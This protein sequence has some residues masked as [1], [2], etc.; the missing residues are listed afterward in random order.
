MDNSHKTS[1][2]KEQKRVIASTATGFS[3]ENMDFNFMSFAL[4]SIIASLGISTTEAGWINT[5]TNLGMLVGG[6]FFGI[7][8]DKYGRVKIFSY[9]IFIFA[10]ATALMYFANN[11]T[12]VYILRFLVGFGEG[13][14]YGAGMALI[15]EYFSEKH[16]GRMTAIASIVCITEGKRM[17]KSFVLRTLA[18]ALMKS[19]TQNRHTAE[20]GA[21]NGSQD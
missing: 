1:L 9:T 19:V 5:I 21:F 16:Y 2:S 17:A 15:A 10:G 13:G 12:M 14:E 20:K 8:S 3:F 4:T 11:L 7:L 6:L 18:S